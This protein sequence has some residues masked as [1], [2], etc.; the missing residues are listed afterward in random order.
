[1]ARART[2]VVNDSMLITTDKVV[3]EIARTAGIASAGEPTLGIEVVEQL[4]QR[5]AAVASGAPAT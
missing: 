2:V 4:Y 5:L 1:M 3:L